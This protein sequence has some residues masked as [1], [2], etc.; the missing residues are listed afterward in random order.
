MMDEFVA[1]QRRDN[2]SL[3]ADKYID[4]ALLNPFLRFTEMDSILSVDCSHFDI[5]TMRF[6]TALATVTSGA[7]SW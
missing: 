1:V 5:F 4:S 3:T 7:A 2:E 6:D